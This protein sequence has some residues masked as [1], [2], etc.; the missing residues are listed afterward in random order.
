MDILNRVLLTFISVISCLDSFW[1]P[2]SVLILK[3]IIKKSMLRDVIFHFLGLLGRLSRGVAWSLTTVP[4]L[5]HHGTEEQKTL[6]AL[7]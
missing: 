3:E 2:L 7:L 5:C 4:P 1:R 6:P